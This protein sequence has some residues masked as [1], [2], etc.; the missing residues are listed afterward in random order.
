MHEKVRVPTIDV[1]RDQAQLAQSLWEDLGAALLFLIIGLGAFIISLDYPVGSLRRMGPGFFTLLVSGILVGI[2]LALAI[3]S[4]KK[5]GG[6]WL[7]ASRPRFLP[8]AGTVRAL[9]FIMLSLLAFAL[10]VRPAGLFLATAVLMF[11]A[12]RAEPGRKVLASLVLAVLGAGVAALIFV[13]GI[14]LP[15]PLWP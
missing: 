2:G 3:L 14:G 10:L 6:K 9:V 7:L 4:L 11:I 13:Y 12:S 5:R 8:Q 1:D 15:M